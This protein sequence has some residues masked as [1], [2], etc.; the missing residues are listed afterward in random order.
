MNGPIQ[1]HTSV[2]QALAT[3][4]RQ[5][6][7]RLHAHPWIGLLASPSLTREQYRT[8]MQAYR[9]F[10]CHVE[11]ARTHV[12]VLDFLSLAP[13]IEAL[14]RDIVALHGDTDRP[15]R[16][17]ILP[18]ED[19]AS[20]LGALYVLHG[21]GFGN[22]VLG[23]NVRDRLPDAP[24]GYL[25]TAFVRPVWQRLEATLEALGDDGP[26]RGRLVRGAESTFEA[27]GRFVSCHCEDRFATPGSGRAASITG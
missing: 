25:D 24:R 1:E 17:P 15:C 5:A 3:H 4:T 8:V 18:L 9:A 13:A 23:R 20:L 12:G 16:P 26:A 6:H 2:R 7:Q 11:S 14:E 21:S 10:S 19:H 22:R 27:F